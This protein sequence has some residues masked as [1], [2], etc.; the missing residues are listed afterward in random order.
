[1]IGPYCWRSSQQRTTIHMNE[2]FVSSAPTK[3]QPIGQVPEP[4]ESLL[5]IPWIGMS[6]REYS[7]I[8]GQ[9]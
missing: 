2:T 8:Q 9:Q 5:P 7:Q 1:M 6:A 3:T 4:L